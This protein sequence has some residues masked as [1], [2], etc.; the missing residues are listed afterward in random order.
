MSGIFMSN[1]STA[2]L[3]LTRNCNF[4]C[5]HCYIETTSKGGDVLGATEWVRMIERLIGVGCRHYILTGGEVLMSK[6]FPDVYKYL[7]VMGCA[8]E[9]FT[10]GSILKQ[11]HINLFSDCPPDS[12]SVTL[13]GNT[14]EQY[15]AVTE[16]GASMRD[17]VE[18]NI[19][20]LRSMGIRVNLGTIL[21]K[22]LA[23]KEESG[24]LCW[25]GGDEHLLDASATHQHEPE[26]AP[27]TGGNP[28]N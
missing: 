17:I 10:N 14:P 11:Y 12:I 1:I 18:R 19:K 9:I 15:R 13:Y 6:A 2:T 8:V 22:L 24:G 5:S 25:T 20:T 26:P 7:M 23:N 4:H 3:E 27:F 21:C 16:C 28:R